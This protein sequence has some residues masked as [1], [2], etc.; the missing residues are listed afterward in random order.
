MSNN[1]MFANGNTGNTGNQSLAQHM[2]EY[3]GE[4]VTIYT[5]SGGASGDGFTGILFSV[6]CSFVRLIT[7]F[8]TAPACPLSDICDE[9]HHGHGGGDARGAD[10]RGR[11]HHDNVV[12]SICDIPIDRIASFC[13]NAV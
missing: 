4:M 1:N 10:G 2:C 12:G 11:R 7:E 6:N 5:T 8:S 3:I 9:E 13:H